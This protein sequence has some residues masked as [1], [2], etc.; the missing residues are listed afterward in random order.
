MSNNIKQETPLQYFHKLSSHAHSQRA[1]LFN[2]EVE[3]A[4]VVK[5]AQTAT[6]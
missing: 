3:F 6:F 1:E 4:L 2:G 5:E